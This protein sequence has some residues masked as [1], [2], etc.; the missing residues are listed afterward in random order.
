MRRRIG[1]RKIKVGVKGKNEKK[2]EREIQRKR[3]SVLG[4]MKDRKEGKAW[5]RIRWGDR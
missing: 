1:K 2:K 4:E 3:Q 5:R